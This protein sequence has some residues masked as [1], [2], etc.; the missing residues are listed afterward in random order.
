MRVDGKM[1]KLTY[2]ISHVTTTAIKRHDLPARTLNRWPMIASALIALLAFAVT[3]GGT[4]VYDDHLVLESDVRVHDL[5]H[6]GQIWSQAYVP[7]GADNLWR[8]IVSTSYAIQWAV[9]GNKPW[10]FHL[11]NILLHAAVAAMVAR[12]GQKLAGNRVGMI[13]G[14]LFALHPI[15]VEAVA[16]VV[17]RAE[18]TYALA[19]LSAIVL[20]LDRPLPLGK[21]LLAALL[22]LMAALCK[23]QGL[24]LP[25]VFIMVLW[26]RR[27]DIN[28]QI[29]LAIITLATAGH[30]LLREYVL[31]MRFD[32]ERS[33]LEYALQP[34]KN[35]RGLDR[36]LMPAAVI[37][38]YLSVMTFPL[39]LSMDYGAAYI[40]PPQSLSDPYLWLGFA[41][42]VGC[43]ALAV[44]AIRKR[45]W[46]IGLCLA[47]LAIM[48]APVSNFYM[49]T[50]VIMAER[51]FYVPSIFLLLLLAMLWNR[52]PWAIMAMLLA[53]ALPSALLRT[54]TYACR[55]NQ[56]QV[57][58]RMG[59]AERPQ[60]AMLALF[61]AEDARAA[62]N[63]DEA[64]ILAAKA[65]HSAPQSYKA[66]LEAGEIERE[67]G[68]WS[69]A[70]KC[71][72]KAADV[73][74]GPYI[75]SLLKEANMHLFASPS[76]FQP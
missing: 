72:D 28:V 74:S 38:H 61:V 15:H 4:F 31:H 39:H 49:I 54:V 43:T 70:A 53:I 51:L 3:L 76:A 20:S 7:D 45:Q 75:V 52:L 46:T 9:H 57:L 66:W 37:G 59:Y 17:G 13:A 11:V 63:L 24:V 36:W 18:L 26:P 12:L 25:L 19:G 41:T 5:H 71:F 73:Q 21:A 8:P 30:I 6:L 47:G 34:L 62:G 14:L 50:G 68:D 69:A 29:L 33:F 1:V 48:Y 40:R 60:S 27:R 67:A 2:I 22:C 32:W 56:P 44:Y 10:P 16:N 35:A 58:N 65:C 23:E 64:R 55:W 42:L